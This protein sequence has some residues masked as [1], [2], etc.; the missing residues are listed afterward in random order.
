VLGMHIII[1]IPPHDI[2]A[3]MP[4]AIIAFI[5]LQRSVIM[6]MPDASIGMILQSIPSFVISQV[7]RHIAGIDIIIGIICMPFII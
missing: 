4:I 5:A 6:S 7:I 2:I 1:G 3:G